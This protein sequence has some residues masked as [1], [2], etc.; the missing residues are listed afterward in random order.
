[1]ITTGRQLQAA[2]VL[3]KLSTMN[4]KSS[5]VKVPLVITK[6]FVI[7]KQLKLYRYFN[8]SS[9]IPTQGTFN[10]TSTTLLYLSTDDIGL[11]AQLSQ[12][13]QAGEEEADVDV[14]DGQRRILQI[15]N[16]V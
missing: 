3:S 8:N 15:V 13:A 1:M 12:P 6:P 14:E 16:H 4:N 2:E 10:K 11:G 7:T 5:F 9:R